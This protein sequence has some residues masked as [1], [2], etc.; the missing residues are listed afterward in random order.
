MRVGCTCVCVGG[1]A[2]VGNLKDKDNSFLTCSGC[3]VDER[4][5][6]SVCMQAPFYG[7]MKVD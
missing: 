2:H 4:G 3:E 1:G 7:N 6:A 5:A